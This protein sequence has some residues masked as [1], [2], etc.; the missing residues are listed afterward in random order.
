MKT[1]TK[2]NAFLNA[3]GGV[4]VVI[5]K[6]MADFKADLKQI[7]ASSFISVQGGIWSL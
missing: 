5:F 3:F 6:K 7:E 1:T 4:V 2:L